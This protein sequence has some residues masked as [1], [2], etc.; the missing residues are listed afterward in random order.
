MTFKKLYIFDIIIGH[1]V[2]L[3]EEYKMDTRYIISSDGAKIA[4]SVAGKGPALLLAH[5]GLGSYSKKLWND[6]NWVKILSDKFFLIMP[7]IRGYGD[8]DKSE[9]PSFYSVENIIE[10][11]N[12][13]LKDCNIE[14]YYYFGW[15]YGATIGF[16]MLKNNNKIKKAVCAGS[17]L[18]DYFFKLVVP[19]MIDEYEKF[20]YHKRT[21]SLDE[22]DL[23]YED[24]LWIKEKN[25]EILIAQCKSWQNWPC[26]TPVDIDTKLAIYS[27][28][29]D[30]SWLLEQ[31]NFQKEE[32]NK[33]NINL[34]IFNNLDH[35]GLINSVDMVLPWVL[36]QFNE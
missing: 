35:Y 8:S 28:T 17:C 26:I 27:G 1:S 20:N 33:H 9:E 13:I 4:Y 14:S 31:L 30:N 15:S 6:T 12:N 19:K 24:K 21:N 36:K 16:Q 18:G 22:L 3:K 5:G 34:K 7:D 11:F 23:T 32:L 25:L 10:D 29:N 2:I